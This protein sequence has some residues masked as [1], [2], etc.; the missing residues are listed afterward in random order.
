[1]IIL[2][3]E[4]NFDKVVFYSLFLEIWFAKPNIHKAFRENE[5]PI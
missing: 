3:T 2:K 1:M 4:L 5:N